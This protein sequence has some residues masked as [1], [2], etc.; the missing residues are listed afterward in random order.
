MRVLVTG[1]A[2]FIGAACCQRLLARGDRVLGVDNLSDYYD[3]T[4]K[5]ARLALLEAQPGFRFVKMDLADRPETARLFGSLDAAGVIHLAAQPGVRYSIERPDLYVSANLVGF[6]NVLE[7]CRRSGVEHLVYASS[8]SVYGGNRTVPFS[9]H[10]AVDHPLSLY[11]A[12]KKAN[13]V[14]AHSYSHLYGLPATGLRFF[15]VYGPWGRPDMSPM[16]FANRIVRGEPLDVYNHGNHRRDFTYVDDIVEGVVRCLD[17]PP[18]PAAD[19]QDPVSPARSASAPYRVF[20]IGSH[21]PVDL[22]R[23]IGLLE[24]A[25]GKQVEKRLLPMQAGDMAETFADVSELIAAVGYQ[26]RTPVEEGI[27]RFVAWYKSYF[28]V[29]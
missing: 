14:M 15:T 24:E 18:A 2:G 3:P 22:M 17:N 7:G 5:Q 23:F 4:L 12:T 21:R 28:G 20:N 19:I 10:H 11:G 9:E 29:A 26:P 1:A 16:I 6:A 8:S 25:F 13:E 27:R